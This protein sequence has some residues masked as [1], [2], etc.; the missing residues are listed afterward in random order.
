MA[1]RP[2]ARS[3]AMGDARERSPSKTTLTSHMKTL[4]PLIGFVSFVMVGAEAGLEQERGLMKTDPAAAASLLDE[5]LKQRPDDAWLIYNRGVAAYASKDF[6]KADELWQQLAATQM[7]DALREHVWTQ[8]G[9]VAFRQVEPVIEKEPDTAVAKLEQSREAFRVAIAFNKKN[10]TAARNLRLVEKRLEE[11]YARLAKRL[12]EEAKKENWAPK[13]V[14]TLQA[15]L[16]Y[17]EQAQALNPQNAE[18]KEEKKSIEKA[19]AERLDQRAAAEEKTADQ[20]NQ[21]NDWERRD[22]EQH[23]QNALTD[24]QQAQALHAEDQVA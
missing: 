21:D 1:A 2:G 22:A 14:E 15:A 17:A 24:F 4:F 3:A 5:Q 10:E 19:L 6:A 23:L 7:P 12:V 11:I 8:I 16:S 18:R 9:N 20:R 13:A